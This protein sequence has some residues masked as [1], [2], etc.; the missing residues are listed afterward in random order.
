MA[1]VR[2]G[3]PSACDALF[4]PDFGLPAG[5]IAGPAGAD[6]SLGMASGNSPS[7]DPGKSGIYRFI[8]ILA[9]LDFLGGLAFMFLAPPLL[10]TSD[11]F[12]LGLAMAV[13]GAF[14]FVFF[15]MLA[16]RAR[17]G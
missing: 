6:L 10:G 7:G 9:A 15:T 17:Q 12:Y 5:S 14:I 8:R 3:P 2:P 1:G 4:G 16:A 11:Y 13:I